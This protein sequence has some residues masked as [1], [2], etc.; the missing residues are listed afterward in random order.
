[1]TSAHVAR[2][3]SP[4]RVNRDAT[5]EDYCVADPAGPPA[6][7]ASEQASIGIVLSGWFEYASNG[8]STLAGPGTLVL[9]NAGELFSVRHLDARGNRRLVT[10]L[11]QDLLEEVAGE[12][13]L[14]PV[15]RATAI[16]P[17]RSAAYAGGLMRAVSSGD[18]GALYALAHAAL[19][20][21][22]CAAPPAANA[23]DRARVRDV[24]GHLE[25]R[26]DQPWPL[27]SLAEIA[28]VSR[29]H[30]VRI[31]SNVVGLTPTRYLINLRV[32]AAADLLL[33]T[34]KP[35]AQII[36][37]VGFNDVSYFYTCFRDT[38]RCTPR[39]WRLRAAS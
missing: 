7:W 30:L 4:S 16:P 25:T 1:M 6:L 12:A 15:F 20:A 24:V 5:V 34:R 2:S 14:P 18:P 8:S 36:Y 13:G 29:F 26:L 23:V 21:P 22:H 39:Q 9:G 10:I 17:G 3:W 33:A 32:R 31:F 35:I 27:Q 37:D 28:G 38:F 11:S 19:G